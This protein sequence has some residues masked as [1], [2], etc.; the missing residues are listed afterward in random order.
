MLIV[1]VCFIISDPKNN[2]FFNKNYFFIYLI[3]S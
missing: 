3:Q 2:N 1:L